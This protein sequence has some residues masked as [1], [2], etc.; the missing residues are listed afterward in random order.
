VAASG[1]IS[2]GYDAR[3]RLTSTSYGDSS[4]GITRT[5]TADGLPETV[6]S[7]GAT[8]TTSYNHRRL[9][10]SEQLSY[11]ST[12]YT[13]GWAYD[14]N[15]HVSQLTYPNND[16]VAYAPNALGEPSQV[17]SYATGITYFPNGAVAGFTYGNGKVRTL[18]QNTRGLPLV[19]KD[20]G[21]VQDQYTYDANGNVAAIAD[22][23]E[24]VTNRTLG[25]DGLDRL[26]SASAPNVW[27]N[28]TYAY[29]TLDNLVSST[30]GSRSN[31][32]SYDTTKNR[33]TSLA[34][35]V[36]NYNY[37]YGYDGQGNITSRGSQ[38][39]TFDMGNRMTAATNKDTYAYDGLGHR[40][41]TV[42]ADGTTTI[43]IYSPAGQLL[44]TA[45]TGG[46]N[47]AK[48]TEY[49]QLHQHEIAE[50]AQ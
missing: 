48:T 23:Q 4:P 41:K 34:S 6:V 30:I 17:G 32:Y 37:T 20:A 11:N 26:T 19:A 27:G 9:P 28:A 24:N 13:L 7:N 1:K 25:Y 42:A 22:Q 8:W 35:N 15:G 33:L 3:N 44:Y 14:S 29:D 39:F 12:T 18:T 38:G 2:Y 45:Q 49:I 21:V 43:S 36:S 40:V 47:P 16:A 46:P 10:T 5:Y 31:V 50:V